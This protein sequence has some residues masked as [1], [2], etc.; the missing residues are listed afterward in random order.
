MLNENLRR[1]VDWEIARYTISP[2]I[3]KKNRD[4]MVFPWEKESGS[5]QTTWTKEKIEQFKKLKPKWFDKK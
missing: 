3:E 4:K 2:H 5:K 1:R